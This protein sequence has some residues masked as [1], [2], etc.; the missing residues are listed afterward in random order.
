MPGTEEKGAQLET[1]LDPDVLTRK[2][3]LRVDGKAVEATIGDALKQYELAS[4]SHGRM[5]SAKELEKAFEGKAEVADM[6]AKA[7]N[8]NDADLFKAACRRASVPDAVIEERFAQPKAHAA[9]AASD[10]DEDDDGFDPQIAALVEHN[11][12]LMARL[13]AIEGTIT[14]AKDTGVRNRQLADVRSALDS[15]PFIAQNMGRLDDEDREELY[16]TAY[17]IAKE[18]SKLQTWGPGAVKVGVDRLKKRLRAFGAG[19]DGSDTRSRGDAVNGFGPAGM[20]VSQLHR[21]AGEP[22]PVPIRDR[23]K[24]GG[25]FVDRMVAKMKRPD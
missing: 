6:F 8:E 15:D 11:R 22:K 19:D 4:A 21:R 16:Q 9:N 2:V 17:S 10:D 3:V 13:E 5:R 20:S 12:Q 1:E 7:I 14:K 25:N 18:A 23:K 24:W